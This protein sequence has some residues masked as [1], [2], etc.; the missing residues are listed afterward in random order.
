MLHVRCSG[1][2]VPP[3]ACR[4]VLAVLQA[5]EEPEQGSLG[6]LVQVGDQLGEFDILGRELLRERA[7]VP[8]QFLA[9]VHAQHGRQFERCLSGMAR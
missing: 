6:F 5:L 1:C 2:G 8:D 4:R 9:K 3:C 7:E